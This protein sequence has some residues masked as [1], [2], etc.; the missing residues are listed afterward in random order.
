VE[1]NIKKAILLES[2]RSQ[3]TSVEDFG[4]RHRSGNRI[5]GG[6]RRFA[7]FYD[8]ADGA[9]RPVRLMELKVARVSEINMKAEI[10]KFF[11]RG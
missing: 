6:H 2:I 11:I 9:R 4:H 10:S 3:L 5:L 7:K 8:R 1:G